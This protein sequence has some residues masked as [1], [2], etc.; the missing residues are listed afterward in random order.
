[1]STQRKPKVVLVDDSSAIRAFFVSALS[2][3]NFELVPFSD[4]QKAL[5]EIVKI[6]PDC[7]LSD[8]EMP[9]MNGIEFCKAVKLIPEC[10]DVPFVVLSMHDNNKYILDCL[11]SGVD[12]YLPKRTNP[13]V[14]VSKVRLMIEVSVARKNQ[15]AHERMKTYAA[16]VATLKHEWNNLFAVLF[17]ILEKLAL[18]KNVTSEGLKIL[19]EA[20]GDDKTLDV[21]Y[22]SLEKVH[23][24]IKSFRDVKDVDFEK[25]TSK[26]DAML[27]KK[28]AS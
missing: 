3:F 5:Q 14:I 15:L 9:H 12:D 16:T 4:P 19:N 11:S 21:L 8:Y 1:M 23:E 17:P 18:R 28:S 10:K 13:E 7:I 27:I 2:E 26:S 22:R 25:Y 24:T 20:G 6:N